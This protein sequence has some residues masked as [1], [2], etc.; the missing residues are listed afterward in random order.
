MIV[1]LQFLSASLTLSALEVIFRQFHLLATEE[2]I[3][4][5]IDEFQIQGIDALVIIFA[6]LILRSF[7]PIY[8]VIIERNLQRFQAAY[9]QLDRQALAG[10]SFTRGRRTSQ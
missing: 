3:K 6:T 9:C 5:L 4:L 2:G 8:K 7:L 10:S 1:H